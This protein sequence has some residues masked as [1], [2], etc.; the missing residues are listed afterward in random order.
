MNTVPLHL[1]PSPIKTRG[2]ETGL[3][4]ALTCRRMIRPERRC[5]RRKTERKT[6][7]VG[8]SGYPVLAV[9]HPERARCKTGVGDSGVVNK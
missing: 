4:T 8:K 3:E 7:G 2:N 9:A 5:G 1:P 6:E